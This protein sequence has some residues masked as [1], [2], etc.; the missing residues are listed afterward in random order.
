[1]LKLRVVES[2]EV[3]LILVKNCRQRQLSTGLYVG[4]CIYYSTCNAFLIF[5]T[6]NGIFAAPMGLQIRDSTLLRS[7]PKNQKGYV[8]SSISNLQRS[9]SEPVL[10]RGIV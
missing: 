3:R 6:C 2:S 4:E 8:E 5:N 9:S 1:M 10:S 7:G